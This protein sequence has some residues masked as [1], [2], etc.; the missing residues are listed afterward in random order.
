MG[1][2]ARVNRL[3]ADGKVLRGLEAMAGIDA[4]AMRQRLDTALSRGALKVHAQAIQRGAKT[5]LSLPIAF[6]SLSGTSGDR[7]LS[8]LASLPAEQ[9]QLV[10]VDLVAAPDGRP[11]DQQMWRA[12]KVLSSQFRLVSVQTSG[13]TSAVDGYL[14]HGVGAFSIDLDDAS[15]YRLQTLTTPRLTSELSGFAARLRARKLVTLL[16]GLDTKP[17]VEAGLAARF[18]YLSGGAIARDTRRLAAPVSA[19]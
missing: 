4:G 6:D 5:L 16:Y 7:L 10:I 2:Q 19:V 11:P 1:Y 9:R 18:T 15:G 3:T 17:L 12:L 13:S 8:Q 14:P